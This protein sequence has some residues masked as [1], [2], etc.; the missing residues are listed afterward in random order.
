MT[1]ELKFIAEWAEALLAEHGLDKHGWTFGFNQ[2]KR[3]LGVCRYAPKRIEVSTY[4]A[5][6]SVLEEVEDTIL[7]EIAHALTPG[8]HHDNVWKAACRSIGARPERLYKGPALDRPAKFI[9]KCVNCGQENPL[10]RRPKS[11][12]AACKR[13]CDRHNAGQYDQ[14]FVLV[15]ERVR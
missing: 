3:R 14:R 12:T 1:S 8:H 7:H 6:Q 4:H 9:R 2:N 5:E 15:L 11:T 13:C 10:F